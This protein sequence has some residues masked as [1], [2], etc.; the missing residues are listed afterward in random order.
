MTA[1][2]R[3]VIVGASS[4]ALACLEG[5]VFTPYLNLTS[6]TLV[7]PGGIPAAVTTGAAVVTG[8]AIDRNSA[9]HRTSGDGLGGEGNVGE[10]AGAKAAAAVLSPVDEDAPDAAR[11]ARMGLER[12]VRV[13]R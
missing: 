2:R 6:V 3:V 1:N 10:D 11:M 7:S 13:V 4:T 9:E 5:L 8:D 12:H